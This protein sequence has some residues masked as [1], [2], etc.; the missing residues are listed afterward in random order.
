MKSL[1]LIDNRVNDLTTVI[2][3]LNNNTNYIIIDYDKDTYNTIIN[4]IGKITSYNNVGIFQENY[5]L[6]YYQFVNA[7]EKSILENVEEIDN[8]LSSW[9]KFKQ[10]LSYF[11][12]VLM[13]SNIDLMGCSIYSNINWNFVIEKFQN[14]IGIN[15]NSSI[16]NTGNAELDGNWILE[17]NNKNL[18][19]L[20]FTENIKKYKFVLGIYNSHSVF[21]MSDGSVYCCGL[22]DQGQL[23]NGN[24]QTQLYP[25][26]INLENIVQVST[27]FFFTSCL[28]NIGEVY[29]FGNNSF[30]QF[31]D[32]SSISK[33]TPTKITSLNN[34]VQVSAGPYHTLF[35]ERSGNVLASGLNSG[36]LGD[37][38]TDRRFTPVQV[39][40]Q[41]GTLVTNMTNVIQVS[42]GYDHSLFLRSDG[43]VYASGLN[44]NGQLG[45]GTKTRFL[46]P[47]QVTN[48]TNVIKISA[49]LEFSLFL[50]STG[51][52]YACGNNRYGQLGPGVSAIEYLNPVQVIEQN[53]NPLTNIKLISVGNDHS[54]FLY[55]DGQSLI[56]GKNNFGQSG[57]GTPV[58]VNKKSNIVNLTDIVQTNTG[59]NSSFFLLGNKNVYS[60]GNNSDG[61]LGDGTINSP[62]YVTLVK[63]NNV[64]I[65]FDNKL[66]YIYSIN[67]YNEKYYLLKNTNGVSNP[68]V[69]YTVNDLLIC[70]VSVLALKSPPYNFTDSDI[71]NSTNVPLF[72][73][74]WFQSY[75]IQQIISVYSAYQLYYI[76]YTILEI[77]NYYITYNYIPEKLLYESGFK[78]SFLLSS[79]P[80]YTLTRLLAQQNGILLTLLGISNPPTF[81]FVYSV[82]DLL[83]T[84]NRIDRKL[85]I[86][87]FV[88]EGVKIKYLYENNIS[89]ENL[90]LNYSVLY[91]LTTSTNEINNDEKLIVPQFR[92]SGYTIPFL[93][94]NNVTILYLFTHGV[95]IQDLLLSYSVLDLLT[96]STNEI[97]SDNKLTVPQFIANGYTISFLVD[98]FVTI[99][100]LINHGVSI[101]NLLSVY[102]SVDLI[103][104][105]NGD[106]GKLTISQLL[107]LGVT[108]RKIVEDGTTI[109]TLLNEPNNYTINDLYDYN[110][111]NGKLN[112]VELRLYDVTFKELINSNANISISNILIFYSIYDILSNNIGEE[113]SKFTIN[114]LLLSYNITIKSIV[115]SFENV[116]VGK[117]IFDLLNTPYYNITVADL[118]TSNNGVD[119]KLT[120]KELI[121]R[122]IKFQQLVSA[123]INISI[124]TLRNEPNNFNLIDVENQLYELLT[125]QDGD[126]KLTVRQLLKLNI[127]DIDTGKFII[128]D[129]FNNNFNIRFLKTNGISFR[130]LRFNC[131]VNILTFINEPN[132]YSVREIL[133]T[134]GG[135]DGNF[136]FQEIVNDGF[137]FDDFFP[138]T[139]DFEISD[140]LTSQSG[141]GKFTFKQINLYGVPISYFLNNYSLADLISSNSGID[142]KFTFKELF[143]NGVSIIDFLNSYSLHDLVSSNNG[144]DGKFTITELLAN[145]VTFTQ[146]YNSYQ[147]KNSIITTLLTFYTVLQLLTSVNDDG[148]LT[149]KNFTD[150]NFSLSFLINN[151]VTFKYLINNGG[152]LIGQLIGFPLFY[153]TINL[154]TTNNGLDGKFTIR[155]LVFDFG[156]KFKNLLNDGIT[157]N[158]LINPPHS[159]EISELLTSNKGVDGKLT[160][161][162]LYLGGISISTLLNYTTNNSFVELLDG[163]IS[164]TT[165]LDPPNNYSISY[166]FQNGV[167]I[168]KMFEN[169]I[170]LSILLDNYNITYLISNGI[171][172]DVFIM[173]G[174]VQLLIDNGVNIFDMKL[175]VA[176]LLFLGFTKDYIF[177]L[178]LYTNF[179]LLKGG[180]TTND[181]LSRGI[182][183]LTPTN[184]EELLFALNS[185]FTNIYINQDLSIEFK[186]IVNGNHIVKKITNIGNKISHITHV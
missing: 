68:N 90:L 38:T 117:T 69:N 177:G 185:E 43:T 174:Y 45:N 135:I 42:A 88:N 70:G 13:V 51:T 124:T 97:N 20:Y 92:A 102:S 52:V 29:A 59:R 132:F 34:I 58:G 53:G 16:D 138:P 74:S 186:N 140:L 55:N 144:I 116:N 24:Y 32:G 76:G 56:C 79:I 163:G 183:G 27:G 134:N 103:T 137:I 57:D 91:L 12:N 25:V 101:Q 159:F 120:I 72:K 98:N 4:K 63:N 147:N 62:L 8:K 84:N 130:E 156:I 142:G 66:N 115:G 128:D 153:K 23:G 95:S 131:G 143:N 83:T 64:T 169:G 73:K 46:N 149:V 31:G 39:K 35:L 172:I 109:Q 181:L 121:N 136:T 139:N 110:G 168:L 67:D 118:L 65:N 106:D 3:S 49:G 19:G 33:I 7:F 157:V 11:K 170:P 40:K 148:K 123:P 54:I 71:L 78:L 182:N 119:G 99:Q 179:E 22:N 10:L 165:L 26:K 96:T 1:L 60:C 6:D 145:N 28:S 21:L 158:T 160:F 2:E 100:Y 111:N 129:F 30:G 36:K 171:S 167:S 105:N 162:Q 180:F 166:L 125:S 9:S 108:I 61:Q 15:I 122:G 150:G 152:V 151:N 107:E 154:I 173:N 133:T 75:T 113:N 126:G 87:D 112:I 184:S 178:N 114:E 41:D 176:T 14:E 80:A 155:E 77:Y 48:M 164:V 44:T 141:D 5:G 175:E 89:I 94:N 86:S 81:N 47:V 127:N 161:N 104:T 50:T 37:G 93:V 18:I 17:S 85:T 146:L 82:Q